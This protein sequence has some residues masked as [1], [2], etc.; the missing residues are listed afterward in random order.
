MDAIDI[1]PTPNYV[2]YSFRLEKL[3]KRGV[4]GGLGVGDV[5][6]TVNAYIVKGMGQ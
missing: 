5:C 2:H 4:G 6:N 1:S 3:K